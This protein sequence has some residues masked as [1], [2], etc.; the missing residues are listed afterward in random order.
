MSRIS[1]FTRFTRF[2]RLTGVTGVTGMTGASLVSGTTA[3]SAVRAKLRKKEERKRATGK[4]G[5]VYEEDYL[6]VSLRKLLGDRL[7]ALQGT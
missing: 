5:S 2:T 6:F 7:Q 4:K 3:R 1:S